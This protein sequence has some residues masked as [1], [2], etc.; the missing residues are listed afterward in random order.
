MPLAG[1]G[2]VHFRGLSTEGGSGNNSWVTA[3]Y[4]AGVEGVVSGLVGWDWLSEV[5]VAVSAEDGVSVSIDI[6][7]ELERG[8]DETSAPSPDSGMRGA[9]GRA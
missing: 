3:V 2:G 4:F 8:L 1:D 9:C 6:I 5:G 7:S